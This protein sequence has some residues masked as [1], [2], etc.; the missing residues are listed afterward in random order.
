MKPRKKV[1]LPVSISVGGR[2]FDVCPMVEKTDFMLFG[3]TRIVRIMRNGADAGEEDGRHFAHHRSEISRMFRDAEEYG[4]VFAGW[5][6]EDGAYACLARI[7][8]TFEW[9]QI[10]LA[11][12]GDFHGWGVHCACQ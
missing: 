11:D 3:R 9:V 10:R 8:D 4:F 5:R 6:S 7:S 2:E 1:Q 12:N